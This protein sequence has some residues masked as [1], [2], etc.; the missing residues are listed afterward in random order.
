MILPIKKH[1]SHAIITLLICS[2]TYAKITIVGFND[3]NVEDAGFT[4]TSE[5]T[6]STGRQSFDLGNSSSNGHTCDKTT[7]THALS[8]TNHDNYDT[9]TGVC[10]NKETLE[11]EVREDVYVYRDDAKSTSVESPSQDNNNS[12]STTSS[13][14][15]D[16][17]KKFSEDQL[18]DTRKQEIYENQIAQ[19]KSTNFSNLEITKLDKIARE[20]NRQIHNKKISSAAISPITVNFK[21]NN[22][23]DIITAL[24]LPTVQKQ[25]QLLKKNTLEC[26]TKDVVGRKN[27]KFV[28]KEIIF[29]DKSISGEITQLLEQ[30]LYADPSTAYAALNTLHAL[31][32]YDREY[33]FLVPLFYNY[34]EERFIH[35]IIGEDIIRI[36]EQDL[37]S[38]QDYIAVY[39]TEQEQQSIQHYKEKCILL[40]QKGDIAT[41]YNQRKNICFDIVTR[42]C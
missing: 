4:S 36:A 2:T 29:I 28:P 31:F 37:F 6:T 26:R 16:W 40:Q 33:Q 32:P 38:R 9:Y 20:Y 25:L 35:S 39:A 10:I 34:M 21:I 8:V 23:N 24:K 11:V 12:N 15:D 22:S 27:F 30:I 5:S 13:Y 41:L 18:N 19:N 14:D 17:K 42:F 3:W 7:H 1:I